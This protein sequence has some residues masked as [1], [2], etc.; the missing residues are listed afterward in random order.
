MGQVYVRASKRAKAYTR[1]SSDSAVNRVL[2]HKGMAQKNFSRFSRSKSPLRA[3]RSKAL[4]LAH[5]HH[6]AQYMRD[7]E[8]KYR[9][10]NGKLFSNT[11][12]YR[13]L[14]Y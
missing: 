3:A 12:L 8:A 7:I 4:V 13:K 1:R 10:R 6:A 14:K 11:S 2:H 5:T 9:P